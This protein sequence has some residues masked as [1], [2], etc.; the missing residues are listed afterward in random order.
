M[1]HQPYAAGE[2]T[3]FHHTNLAELYS[4]GPHDLQSFLR[5]RRFKSSCKVDNI[6]QGEKKL[7]GK[8]NSVPPWF[9]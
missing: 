3:D 7:K 9:N 4:K 2:L 1:V 5:Q 8:L 6:F